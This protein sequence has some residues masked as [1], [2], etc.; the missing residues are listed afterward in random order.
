MDDQ[1]KRT[2]KLVKMAGYQD[3]GTNNFIQCNGNAT[4]TSSENC[5]TLI[6]SSAQTDVYLQTTILYFYDGTNRGQ[7]NVKTLDSTNIVL[8]WTTAVNTNTIVVWEAWA[9]G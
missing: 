6:N 8:E 4:S 9:S 7:A 1:H 5:I 3:Q 2:P